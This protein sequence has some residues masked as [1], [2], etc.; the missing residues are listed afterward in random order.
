MIVESKTLKD[1]TIVNKYETHLE[2]SSCGMHVDAE[3][4]ESG[5]C[6]DCG[7]AWNGKQ[8]TKV[9]VTSVPASGQT[10]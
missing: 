8:H 9:Y 4:Y 10:S 7:A 1:G 2:C 6:S 5:I 3:E